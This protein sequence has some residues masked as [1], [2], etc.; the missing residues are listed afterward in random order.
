MSNKKS[1]NVFKES[2]YI[3]AEKRILKSDL[4]GFKNGQDFFHRECNVDVNA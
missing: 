2:V 4:E 1:L 3:Y